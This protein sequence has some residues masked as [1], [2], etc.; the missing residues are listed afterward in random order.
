MCRAKAPWSTRAAG[1][2]IFE[3]LREI[4]A[5]ELTLVCP[6]ET[7]VFG[8][9]GTAAG[10][11]IELHDER[12]FRRTLLAGD[13]GFGESYM[14]GDWSSP[15]L[16]DTLRLLVRNQ[17]LVEDRNRRFTLVMRWIERMRHLLRSNTLAGSRR[18]IAHHYDLGNDFYR[19]FLDPSMAYSCA[20]YEMPQDSLEL[21][22]RRK[23]DRICRKLLLGPSDHLLEIGTGWGGL[24]LH[25]ARH[26]GCQVTTTT[27]SREQFAYANSLVE[28]SGLSAQVRVLLQDYRTLSGRF[29]KIVSV[30]MFE[31]VGHRNYDAFFGQCDRLLEPH[32]SMLLQTITISDQRFRDYRR[33]CDWVQKHIFPGAELASMGGILRSLARATRLQ[34]FHAEDIGMHYSHT[35]RAWRERFHAALP[36]VRNLGFEDRFIRMWDYYL[37]CCEAA[38]AERS[39]GNVQLLLTRA[40]NR[41]RMLG[42]PWSEN[43]NGAVRQ[44]SLFGQM[45]EENP[46]PHVKSA[47]QETT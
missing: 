7:Y 45:P 22:Q 3:L 33:R 20:L 35:L 42:E 47:V 30:E 37:A 2:I 14:D 17:N 32:G 19:L 1:R 40:G 8:V 21:A 41:A 12:F 34:L 25:A 26:Y 6:D 46:L 13:V 15:N 44:D 10:G 43:E 29:D 36:Q 9:P 27:I 16:V 39:I 31:A 4:R 24:A 38:F 23:Y 11:I 5:G 28:R 18:N